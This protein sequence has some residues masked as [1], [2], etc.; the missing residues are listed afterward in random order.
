MIESK[1]DILL[2]PINIFLKNEIVAGAL[3]FMCAVIAMIWANS[4]FKESYHHLWETHFTIGFGN[5]E[6]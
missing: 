6:V 5:F 1:I 3:L 2:K 4:S